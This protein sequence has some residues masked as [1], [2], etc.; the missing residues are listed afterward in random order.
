MQGL[1]I[2]YKCLGKG[3]SVILVHGGANDWHE[4]Q[5]NIAFI[6]RSFRVYAP[7][8]PGFGLSQ[9]P[10]T[11]VSLSWAVSFLRDFMDTLGITAAHLIGHSLGGMVAL[12][13][14]LDFPE[15][16]N[17]LVLT[18]SAGLG[19]ISQEGWLR[20]FLIGYACL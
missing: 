4:W 17:K 11:P 2:H 9:S 3:A 10:S 19:E 15:R 5:K 20:L 16:V 6:A 14:A 7:D 12:A 13:F 1:D 8:L 18:D